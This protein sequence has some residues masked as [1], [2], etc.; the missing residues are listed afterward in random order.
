M[1]K[2]TG[3]LM[4]L[5]ASG[6][7][8]STITFS[9]WKGRNYVRQ[10]VTPSNPKTPGQTAN[11][12]MFGFLASAWKNLG[13][14]PQGSWEDAAKQLNASPFNAYSQRN[15]KNWTQNVTP[16]ENAVVTPGAGPGTVTSLTAAGG[17]RQITLTLTPNV[18]N[19]NWGVIVYRNATTGFVPSKN[20]VII[21]REYDATAP[22]NI[23]DTNLTP[24]TYF[25]RIAMFDH[26][27]QQ[28]LFITEAT[29]T[30]S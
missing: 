28:A 4:S 30:A 5:D 3:P 25:Y 17:V 16:Q 22:I 24:G 12:A 8:A 21:V 1:A 19:D 11:R 23:D 6:S 9:K 7:V 10:T 14:T 13:A 26:Q 18:A 15:Q 2:I 27:T 29:A 20:D